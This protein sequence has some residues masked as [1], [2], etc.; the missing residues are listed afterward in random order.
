MHRH[1]SS[2]VV[3]AILAALLGYTWAQ[4]P[5]LHG[6]DEHTASAL[7]TAVID[8]SRVF[9][10]YKPFLE[11]Q[12]EMLQEFRKVEET[13]KE[14]AA[15]DQRLQE[16]FKKAQPGSPEQK[17]LA[18]TIQEKRKAF[19]TF[20]RDVQR[21]LQTERNQLF[22]ETYD[23]IVEQ[24]QQYADTK[25]IRL[26]VSHRGVPLESRDPRETM[27]KLQRPIV[28]HN[29]LDITDDILQALN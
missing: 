20:Q 5:G 29:L 4:R 14:M 28:Y 24:I 10:G 16:E 8:L 25:G 3:V 9:D 12:A 1:I 19:E 18:E 7:S 26:V 2:P 6:D 13:V 15:E 27:N 22:S 23:R 11:K 17:R 21:R